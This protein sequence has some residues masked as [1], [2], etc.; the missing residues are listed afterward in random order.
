MVWA[1][2]N[3]AKGRVAVIRPYTVVVSPTVARERVTKAVHIVCMS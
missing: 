2:Q 1:S 3:G